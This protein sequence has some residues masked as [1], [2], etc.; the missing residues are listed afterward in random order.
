MLLFYTIYSHSTHYMCT[1]AFILSTYFSLE[2]Y[3]HK[4]RFPY[5]LYLRFKQYL[6]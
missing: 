4:P 6:R 3:F 1:K 2:I 5:I